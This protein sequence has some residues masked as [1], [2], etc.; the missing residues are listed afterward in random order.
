MIR[1][2]S[3]Q[4]VLDQIPLH[5]TLFLVPTMG[6]LH[7]GHE[8]LIL[9]AKE[10]ARERDA[11]FGG[12]SKVVVSIFVNPIQ[13]DR[14][15]DLENYPQP[16]EQDLK[17]CEALGVD[18]VFTPDSKEFY[19]S[20]RSIK[21]SENSLSNLLCGATRPGH[22]DG[23]CTVIA[24]LFNLF[25]PVGAIF[26]EKDYQQLAIIRRLVR[27]LNFRTEVIGLATVREPSG[28]AM[29]SRNLRLNE[30]TREQAPAIRTA[31]LAALDKFN[32]GTTS[33]DRLLAIIRM[34]LEKN[35]PLSKI[36]YL[37]CVCAE[38]LKAIREVES[39]AV[40][41]IASFFGEVR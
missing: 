29:S 27:D 10:R 8:A 38:T 5:E 13:F 41:A 17:K 1:L 30:E 23:V 15:S 28:L 40:I 39:P 3:T 32:S 37:E 36:D 35:A 12:Q 20:D 6:A 14:A 19:A 18:Y 25:R 11:Q 26:G 34:Y 22:F 24:K 33:A 16:I 2:H 7:F 31:M 4:D 9:K 21:V